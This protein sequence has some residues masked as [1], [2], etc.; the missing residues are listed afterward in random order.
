MTL[1]GLEVAT[2]RASKQVGMINGRFYTHSNPETPKQCS[3][4][5]ISFV[6]PHLEYVVQNWDLHH[7]RHI[8]AREKVQKFALQMCF[9]AWGGVI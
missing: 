7:A 8:N 6:R 1:A 2:K 5:Y 9:K 3:S 4:S